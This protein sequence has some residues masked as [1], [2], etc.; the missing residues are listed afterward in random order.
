MRL[1][2]KALGLF[3]PKNLTIKQMLAY[4][5]FMA[6]YLS[7]SIYSFAALPLAKKSVWRPMPAVSDDF[8]GLDLRL[9]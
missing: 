1:Q 3:S 5:S 2:V 7:P 4:Q 6:A 8:Q 9:N